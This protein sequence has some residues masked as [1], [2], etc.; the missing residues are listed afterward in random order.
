LL[1]IAAAG[2]GVFYLPGIPFLYAAAPLWLVLLEIAA[3]VGGISGVAYWL[4]RR[5][6]LIS[7]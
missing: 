1:A 4:D 7:L 6:I 2:I 5:G 3:L